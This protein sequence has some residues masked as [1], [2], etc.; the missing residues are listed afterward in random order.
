LDKLNKIININ[1]INF[2]D[3]ELD[4]FFRY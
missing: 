1:N 4:Q 2:I 3:N